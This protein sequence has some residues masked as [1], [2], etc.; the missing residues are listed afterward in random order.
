MAT[1]K[2]AAKKT[3]RK[4]K[5]AAKKSASARKKSP[6]KKKVAT[7]KKPATKKK[8]APKK[9]AAKRTVKKAVK[10]VA[11]K[12]AKKSPVK[13]KAAKKIVPQKVNKPKA[14]VKERPPRVTSPLPPQAGDMAHNTNASP[15]RKFTHKA[16]EIKEVAAHEN[17][18]PAETTGSGSNSMDRQTIKDVSEDTDGATNRPAPESEEKKEEIEGPLM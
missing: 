6:A 11:K 3:A 1:K 4:I 10:K 7:K 13:A 15:I 17:E 2:K 5:P 18:E 16:H 14:T 12:A 9:A 8:A